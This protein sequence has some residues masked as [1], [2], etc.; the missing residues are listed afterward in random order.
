M[1]SPPAQP[2]SG[3]KF[4][5]QIDSQGSSSDSM[6]PSYTFFKDATNNFSEEHKVGSG[7]LGHVYKAH[8]PTGELVAVKLL[9]QLQTF[10]QKEFIYGDDQL[11]RAKHNNIAR[12]FGYSYANDFQ[13]IQFDGRTLRVQDVERVVAFEYVPGG[14]LANFLSDKNLG[15]HWGI[16]FKI[17]KGICEGLQYLHE[18]GIMHFDLKPDN[19]LLNDEKIPKITDFGLLEKLREKD[20]VATMNSL[21]SR[22]YSPPEFLYGRIMTE[23]YDIFSLGVIIKKIMTGRMDYLSI[24]AMDGHECVDHVYKNWRKWLQ[25]IRKYPSFEAD[26]KQVRTCIEIAVACTK[27]KPYERPLMNDIVH[28]LYEVQTTGHYPSSEIEWGIHE[29]RKMSFKRLADMTSNFDEK[30]GHDGFGAVYKGKLEDGISIAV[31]RLDQRSRKSEKQFERVVSLMRLEHKNVVRLAGYCYETRKVPVPDDKNSEL[32]VLQ[33]VIENLFCCEFLPNGNLDRILNDKY[34]EFDWQTRHRIIG[35]ICE[36][37]HHLHVECEDAPIIHEGIK[38]TNILLDEGMVPKLGDFCTSLG[39][40]PRGYIAPEVMDTG[41]V[42]IKSNIYSVGVLI[43]EIAIGNKCP[44]DESSG[45]SYIDNV[46]KS[47]TQESNVASMHPSLGQGFFLQVECW[48]KIG[49]KC[50][51]IEP[52][53]RPAISQIIHFLET[54]S[55]NSEFYHHGEFI[56]SSESSITSWSSSGS[57]VGYINACKNLYWSNPDTT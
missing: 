16:R 17:I 6:M 46:L 49:L 24:A 5:S 50:V 25:D 29:A 52:Q 3:S 34:S 35:G 43:I 2:S 41:K 4:L 15:L 36:G 40:T 42:T 19:I 31:K 22:E 47:Q 18:A 37:L 39:V 48:I 30:L 38:P 32:Y 11:M 1:S 23:A 9:Y 51:E 55:A 21:G 28:K 33:D 14:S 7:K 27:K 10:S 57:Q 56:L 20:R 54:E 45:R 53:K 13:F 8:L 12:F 44:N 26:C